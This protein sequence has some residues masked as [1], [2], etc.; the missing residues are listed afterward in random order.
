[1]TNHEPECEHNLLGTYAW[2]A[3]ASLALFVLAAGT[4]GLAAGVCMRAYSF[5][6]GDR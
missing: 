5:A 3:V 1:M 6:A 2:I 4:C